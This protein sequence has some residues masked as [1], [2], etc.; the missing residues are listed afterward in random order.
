MCKIPFDMESDYFAD[1]AN[2]I[3]GNDRRSD[4]FLLIRIDWAGICQRR[5]S[6]LLESYC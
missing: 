6:L 1:L 2:D 4:P 3:V 5:R